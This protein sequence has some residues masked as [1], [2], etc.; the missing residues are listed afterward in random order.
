MAELSKQQHLQITA[1]IES[2]ALLLAGR[3]DA[4]DYKISRFEAKLKVM[5]QCSTPISQPDRTK[6]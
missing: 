2:F 6:F 1:T 4:L 5:V 3:I